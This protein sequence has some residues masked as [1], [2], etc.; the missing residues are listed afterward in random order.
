MMDIAFLFCFG[1]IATILEIHLDSFGVDH[2][3]IAL[4]FVLESSVYLTCCLTLGSLLKNIDQR[5]CMF[6]GTFS[7]TISY[8]MLGPYSGIFPKQVW[9]IVISLIF[10]GIGQSLT[11]SNFYIVFSIP[12]MLKSAHED[13]GLKSDDILTDVIS[14]FVVICTSTGSILGPLYSGF[15]SS[16]LGIEA[17][18]NIAAIMTLTYA[19]IFAIVS[20]LVHDWFRKN[21]KSESLISNKI[22]PLI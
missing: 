21:K 4:L 11:Y 1:F 2:V 5:T 3:Y 6:C 10:M 17:S 8:L 22:A 18:C 9:V 16:W 14:S 12:Y 20:G 13:Y 15:I 7:L 19:I